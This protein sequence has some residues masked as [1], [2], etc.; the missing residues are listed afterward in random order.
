MV[1]YPLRAAAM[2]QTPRSLM[3]LLQAAP[4][5]PSCRLR[6]EADDFNAICYVEEWETPEEPDRQIR[7]GHCTELPSLM[8]QATEP[9]DLRLSW[10]IE[11]KG[12]VPGDSEAI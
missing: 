11:V 8:E 4:G 1:V 3:P 10:V 6:A 5:R 7:S 2:I 9:P 12:R